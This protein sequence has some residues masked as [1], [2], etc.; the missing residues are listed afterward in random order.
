MWIQHVLK[1]LFFFCGLSFL[2]VMFLVFNYIHEKNQKVQVAKNHAQQETLKATRKFNTILNELSSIAHTIADDI[3]TGQLQRKDI[4]KRLNN[5]LKAT[6]NLFGIG[7]A[8]IPYV[9]HPQKRQLSPYYVNR[10]GK[11]RSKQDI[12]QVFTVP[13]TYFDNVKQSEI[14]TGM[15][16]VDYLSN[17]IKALMTSLDLGR[18]GYGFI[19]SEEGVFIAHPISDYVKPS[20][21]FPSRRIVP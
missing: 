4:L 10:E 20:N 21:Y 17:D 18:T 1:I 15:V 6:P 2:I 13:I 19:L 3:S 7:V 8:F 9:N 11:W 5:T 16:F 14:T 12:L